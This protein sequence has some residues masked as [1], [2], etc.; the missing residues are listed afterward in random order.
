MLVWYSTDHYKTWSLYMG[1]VRQ[2]V[3][4][5]SAFWGKGVLFWGKKPPSKCF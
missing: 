3:R 1:N 4:V 5:L 2:H